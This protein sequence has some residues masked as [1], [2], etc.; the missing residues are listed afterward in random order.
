MA[1]TRRL[2]LV[3]AVEL[4][5]VAIA[6]PRAFACGNS[7][8]YSYAGLGDPVPAFG[9]SAQVTDLADFTFQHGHVA[10]WVGVGGPGQG[11]NGSNEW[12]QMGLSRF[13]DVSGSDVYYEVA[14]PSHFPVYHQVRAAVPAGE[15]VKLAV[16][17]MRGRR[18]WWRVWL[19]NSAASNPIF[20]PDS[21]G[22]WGPMAT[23]E[24]WDG[25]TRGACNSFLYRFHGVRFAHA[26]GGG[27]S[28]SPRGYAIR[29]SK[30]GV[31]RARGGN[32]F[33]AAEGWVARRRLASLRP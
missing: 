5:A 8:G 22:R 9:V 30:T 25:D 10:A 31:R 18:N 13:S 32:A 23:A 6:A 19:N 15:P 29:D 27:W 24:G 7:T 3:T 4:F 17:E 33:L 28:A 12:L 16:L 11:P 2:L 26:P 1:K 20:L 14:L 21:H